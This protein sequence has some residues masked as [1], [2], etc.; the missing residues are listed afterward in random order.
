[1]IRKMATIV[2]PARSVKPAPHATHHHHRAE[3]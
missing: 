1:M 3:A 2:P